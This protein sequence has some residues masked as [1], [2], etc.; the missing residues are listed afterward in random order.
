MALGMDMLALDDAALA[1]L[2][3]AAT[4]VSPKK[5]SRWL[6]DIAAKLEPPPQTPPTRSSSAA[7]RQARVRQ[8]RKNGQH[9]YRL[10]LHDTAVEGLV[11]MFLTTGSLTERETLDHQRLEAEL[12]RLL[13]EQ[14][15]RWTR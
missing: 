7:V 13:E 3:I 4:R 10:V 12:A 9:I 5:R 11:E 14:G 6:R 8:R 15:R 1:R 2:C